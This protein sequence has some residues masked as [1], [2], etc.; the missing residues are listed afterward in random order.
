MEQE[1][2]CPKVV[3]NLVDTSA[4]APT[5]THVTMRVSKAAQV[6]ATGRSRRFQS[7]VNAKAREEEEKRKFK[8]DEKK[9]AREAAWRAMASAAESRGTS[10]TMS[11]TA[12]ASTP[13]PKGKAEQERRGIQY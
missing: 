13:P 6:N 3:K 2:I 10:S 8:E 11:H 9:K 12:A 5:A 7:A 1:L 4:M